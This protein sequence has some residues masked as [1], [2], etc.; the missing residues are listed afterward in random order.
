L[1]LHQPDET[2]LD[3]EVER[4][5]DSDRRSSPGLFHVA[6]PRSVDAGRL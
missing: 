1:D 6:V 5:L 2:V 4:A 3:T